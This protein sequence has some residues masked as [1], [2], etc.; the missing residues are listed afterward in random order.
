MD[1]EKLKKNISKETDVKNLKAYYEKARKEGN[2]KIENFAF[3]RICD[4]ASRGFADPLERDFWGV[5]DAYEIYLT[6]KNGKPTRASRLR[7]KI[8]NKGFKQCLIDWAKN[9]KPTDGFELLIDKGEYKL[10]GEY[11]IIKYANE[12]DKEVVQS[13]CDRLLD[14]L[15]T[16]ANLKSKK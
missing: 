11:L 1:I 5:L 10:T 7:P 4:I 2:K 8:K 14:R 3:R 15:A 9:S 13:A 12:F 6:E 16:L